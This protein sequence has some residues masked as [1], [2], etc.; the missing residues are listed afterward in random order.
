MDER[1]EDMMRRH[2]RS[3]KPSRDS[4][5]E[6]FIGI[7]HRYT[8]EWNEGTFKGLCGCHAMVVEKVKR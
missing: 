7:V 8:A 5:P 1:L 2:Q 3:F 4:S 6:R